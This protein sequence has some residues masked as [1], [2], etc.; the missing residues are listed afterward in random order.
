MIYK[1]GKQSGF[2]YFKRSWVVSGNKRLSRKRVGR[3]MKRGHPAMRKM[4]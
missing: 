1:S 2:D 3:E 4:K